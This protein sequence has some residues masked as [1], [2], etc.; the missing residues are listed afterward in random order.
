[1]AAHQRSSGCTPEKQRLHTREA[2]AAH[3][4]SSGC[5]PDRS[6]FH[7]LGPNATVPVESIHLPMN[8]PFKQF[9]Q[10]HEEEEK[11]QTFRNH[12]D[13]KFPANPREHSPSQRHVC[14]IFI[15]CIARVTHCSGPALPHTTLHNQQPPREVPFST[16]GMAIRVPG[17]ARDISM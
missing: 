6:K 16:R 8:F 12:S 1:M 7:S 13:C 11:H 15:R 5:T 17:S 9:L 4:I 10:R 14:S 3:Q 2:V